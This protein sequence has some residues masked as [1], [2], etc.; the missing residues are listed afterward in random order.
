MH[1]MLM[2]ARSASFTAGIWSV[3]RCELVSHELAASSLSRVRERAASATREPG[4]G[5]NGG[6]APLPPRFRSAPSPRF[7]GRGKEPATLADHRQSEG[8]LLRLAAPDP[9]YARRRGI[10]SSQAIAAGTA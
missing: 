4:E 7:A 2:S 10:T 8:A 3:L 9:R 5:Q 6:T 1:A